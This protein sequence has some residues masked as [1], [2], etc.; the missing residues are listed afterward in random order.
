MK[1]E[2][3][4]KLPWHEY[5]KISCHLWIYR[6]L[7]E[8]HLLSDRIRDIFLYRMIQYGIAPYIRAKKKISK[9][10]IEILYNT[11]YRLCLIRK[12]V[13]LPN[14][15]VIRLYKVSRGLGYFYVCALN[16]LRDI[17]L[18]LSGMR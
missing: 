3:F 13:T 17:R 14:R 7:E 11:Y 10:E 4:K 18:K 6:F 15:A 1:P 16:F 2:A 8:N 9:D 12:K 5:P